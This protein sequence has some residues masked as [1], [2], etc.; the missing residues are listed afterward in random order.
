MHVDVKVTRNGLVMINFMYELDWPKGCPDNCTTYILGV[1][2][3]MFLEE[4][5]NRTK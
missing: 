4:I 2:G 3:R 1:S 5:S